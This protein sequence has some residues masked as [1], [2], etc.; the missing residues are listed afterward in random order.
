MNYRPAN[1]GMSRLHPETANEEEMNQQPPMETEPLEETPAPDL[2]LSPQQV[3]DVR[4]K[5]VDVLHTC[6]D[7][8]IPVNIYE[9]GLIYDLQVQPTGAVHI[10]M[11]L[12][13]PACPVAGSLVGEVE[14]KVRK[15]AN[16][17]TAAVELVWDPPW[18]QERMSEAA[19]LQLGIDW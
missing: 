7:P 15:V 10:Q 1:L 12:T 18:T 6:F 19:K 11:T 16:V 17:S 3:E 8:E 9:L 5:I 2:D 4:R 14:H 13:S